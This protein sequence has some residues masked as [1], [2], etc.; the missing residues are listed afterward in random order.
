MKILATKLIALAITT[1][2]F[3]SLMPQ[4]GDATHWRY[5]QVIWNVS[6]QSTSLD[7]D[8]QITVSPGSDPECGP[9]SYLLDF[10]DGSQ[11]LSGS[12]SGP[13]IAEHNYAEAG[14]YLVS[15]TYQFEVIDHHSKELRCETHTASYADMLAV[16]EGENRESQNRKGLLKNIYIMI[17]TL[18][19][20]SQSLLS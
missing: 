1:I 5:G 11:P 6:S 17:T 4:D 14:R 12:S 15:L 19:K 13:R 7:V 2:G 16:G 3:I 8:L 18:V 20:V 10:G 9:D